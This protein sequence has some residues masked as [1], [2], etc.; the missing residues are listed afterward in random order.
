ME[1]MKNLYINLFKEAEM[2]NPSI[3]TN[4]VDNSSDKEANPN[5]TP[6]PPVQITHSRPHRR[7]IPW[8]EGEHS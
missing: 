3:N 1:E 2:E 8:T 6:P 4:V 7:G 5:D